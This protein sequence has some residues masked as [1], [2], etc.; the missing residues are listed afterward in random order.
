MGNNQLNSQ[1]FLKR[2]KQVAQSYAEESQR[3]AEDSHKN[4]AALC[5]FLAVLRI[6]KK[7]KKRGGMGSCFNPQIT[8][9]N[10]DE[11]TVFG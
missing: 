3:A 7:C 10:T 11:N 6:T 8:R 9:I 1:I 4:S 5:V 2:Q